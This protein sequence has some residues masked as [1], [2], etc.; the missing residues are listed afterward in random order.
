MHDEYIHGTTKPRRIY[1]RI[2]DLHVDSVQAAGFET[3][4]E[5]KR[6][7]R[8]APNTLLDRSKRPWGTNWKSERGLRWNKL[9]N[10]VESVTTTRMR[11]CLRAATRF[12]IYRSA[13]SLDEYRFMYFWCF[14]SKTWKIGKHRETD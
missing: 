4:N 12:K 8:R 3:A 14:W 10:V 11:G 7:G 9:R 13:R 1:E 2:L 5:R 6:V